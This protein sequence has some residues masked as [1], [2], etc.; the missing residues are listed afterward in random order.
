VVR[1]ILERD[2]AEF[3]TSGTRRPLRLRD[4]T[5]LARRLKG[6]TQ[7][8]MDSRKTDGAVKRVLV[9]AWV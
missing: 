6:S 1:L 2:G 9:I 8:L 3:D 5:C 7:H 4:L